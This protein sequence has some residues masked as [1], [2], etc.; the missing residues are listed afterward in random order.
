[1]EPEPRPL[2]DEPESNAFCGRYVSIHFQTSGKQHLA[3]L[4]HG[5]NQNR[6]KDVSALC[7]ERRDEVF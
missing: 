4:L 1:L 7:M 2:S 3:T 5:S 6:A